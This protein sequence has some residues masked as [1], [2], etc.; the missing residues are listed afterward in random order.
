MLKCGTKYWGSLCAGI[1]Q[2]I[3][4]LLLLYELLNERFFFYIINSSQQSNFMITMVSLVSKG[5]LSYILPPVK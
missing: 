3:L 4:F 2:I 5:N 1:I